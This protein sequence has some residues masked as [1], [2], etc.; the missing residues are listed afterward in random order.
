[1]TSIVIIKIPG[2]EEIALPD[3]SIGLL[4]ALDKALEMNSYEIV[5]KG[6]PG[7][8]ILTNFSGHKGYSTYILFEL[9]SEF[10]DSAKLAKE[11]S[12]QIAC[13]CAPEIL[14]ATSHYQ[15]VTIDCHSIC[16]STHK[17]SVINY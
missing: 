13:A 4:K 17:S 14:E 7:K 5:Y 2:N 15:L 16:F 8:K 1:M 9:N 12:G 3:H 6:K 11:I 10:I